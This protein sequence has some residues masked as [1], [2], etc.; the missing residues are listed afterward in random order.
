MSPGDAWLGLHAEIAARH[1]ERRGEMV[2]LVRGYPPK[3]Y[4]SGWEVRGVR[5]VP[6]P[7]LAR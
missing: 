2:V 4:P 3:E 7:R 6:V 1:R 5:I